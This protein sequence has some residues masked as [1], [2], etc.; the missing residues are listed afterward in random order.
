MMNRFHFLPSYHYQDAQSL[1]RINSLLLPNASKTPLRSGKIYA[2]TIQGTSKN[3]LDTTV[4]TVTACINRGDGSYKA[5]MNPYYYA[6]IYA[7]DIIPYVM[8]NQ[9]NLTLTFCF[10]GKLRGTHFILI[11]G[12]DKNGKSKTVQSSIIGANYASIVLKNDFASITA[13]EL[14]WN[15]S[16]SSYTDTETVIKNV[17]LFEGTIED[18][19][20]G[21]VSYEMHASPSTDTPVEVF[22]VGNKTDDGY[23]IPIEIS[24]QNTT[25]RINIYTKTPLYSTLA[26]SD[27]IDLKNKC[28]V[29]RLGKFTLTSSLI[30]SSGSVYTY[31]NFK[32]FRFPLGYNMRTMSRGKG[33]CTYSRINDS[34]MW[35]G[36]GDKNCYFSFPSLYNSADNNSDRLKNFRAWID[37]LEAPFEIIYPLQTVVTESISIPDISMLKGDCTVKVLTDITP[38]K[39]EL[40]YY[41]E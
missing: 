15:A 34:Y 37:S 33:Y 32:G 23:E 14:R 4:A 5:N 36:V 30:A 8:K 13:I 17:M 6:S 10:E 41:K 19:E 35:L 21:S 22:G 18:M 40:Q 9:D 16:T 25:K 3:L 31:N 7:N 24:N 20:N 27:Y 26:D 11:Y 2:R 28:I 39:I 38:Q 1:S 12:T 29:R